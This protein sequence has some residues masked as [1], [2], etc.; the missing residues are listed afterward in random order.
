MTEMRRSSSGTAVQVK[1]HLDSISPTTGSPEG[2][3][4]VTLYGTGLATV[5]NVVFCGEEATNVK[6][7]STQVTC[8]APANNHGQCQ[9]HVVT[10]EN[11]KSNN[12]PFK[13]S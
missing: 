11:Q 5:T 13:Y 8:K 6:P 12:L 3:F 2:G 9:V 1:P 10:R 4:D 7:S